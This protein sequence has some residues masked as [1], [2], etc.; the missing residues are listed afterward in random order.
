MPF[1]DRVVFGS[2]LLRPR[3][4]CALV[5]YAFRTSVGRM[6]N[7]GDKLQDTVCMIP[8]RCHAGSYQYIT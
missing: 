3:A 4:A 1:S 6:W 5:V 2:A 8:D 7:K